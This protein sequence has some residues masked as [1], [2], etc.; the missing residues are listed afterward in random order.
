MAAFK[1]A[2]MPLFT[3]TNSKAQFHTYLAALLGLILFL[4]FP[5]HSAATLTGKVVGIADGDT[6]TVLVENRQVKVRLHG[7]DCPEKGQA[8]GTKAKRFTAG[9]VTGR[10]VSLGVTDTDRYGRT[11]AIVHLED[12]RVLNHEIVRAGFAWWY[13]KYAPRDETLEALEVEAMRG[14]ITIKKGR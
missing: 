2:T 10:T 14:E 11:V 7:I 5:L 4:S 8:F 1:K 12:G 9:L 6:I 13:R 3:V